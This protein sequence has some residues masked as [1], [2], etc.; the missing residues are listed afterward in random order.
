MKTAFGSS[1][2]LACLLIRRGALLLLLFEICTT[3]ATAQTSK[4]PKYRLVDLGHLPGDS[5]I[6]GDGP[7][8]TAINES[9]QI[10]GYEYFNYQPRAFVYDDGQMQ[11]LGSFRAAAINAHGHIVGSGSAFNSQYRAF[12]YDGTMRDL[13]TLGGDYSQASGINKHDQVVGCSLLPKY[14]VYHAFLYDGAMHDLGTLS[15]LA[16]SQASGI[17]DKGQIVGWCLEQGDHP[18]IRAFLYDGSFHDLGTLGGPTAI[19]TAINNRGIVVGGADTTS[20]GQPHPFLYDGSMHDLAAGRVDVGGAAA[21]INDGDQVVGGLGNG[22]FL[23]Q[24]GR[25]YELRQLLDSSG[26]G[27]EYFA[28]NGINNRGQIVGFGYLTLTGPIHAFR[29]DPIHSPDEDHDQDGA[30]AQSERLSRVGGGGS[31]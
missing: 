10:T 13:G 16:L 15:G 26:D 9:G 18:L 2:G 27:W 25:L 12:L 3:I 1:I 21:A 8:A 20:S 4:V 22:S 5:Q 17:N 24:K 14:G 11:D 19:A 23:Y 7:I 31:Q 6:S 29:M 28:P 30:S